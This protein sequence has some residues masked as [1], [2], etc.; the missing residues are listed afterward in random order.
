M[1][2]FIF[3]FEIKTPFFEKTGLL[4]EAAGIKSKNPVIFFEKI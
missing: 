2:P 1:Q 4:N 3:H